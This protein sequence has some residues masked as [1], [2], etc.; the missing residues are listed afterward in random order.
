MNPNPPRSSLLGRFK[1]L[2]Q[3]SVIYGL[4]AIIQRLSGFIL[5]P[6]YTTSLS[7]SDYAIL[8]LVVL[9]GQI[10]E[11]LF[12]M[13]L[14]SSMFRSY[15][16]Y[17]T[18][19]ERKVVVATTYAM[20]L[21]S[22][23]LLIAI[24]TV[25]ATPLAAILL[26]D[27][28]LSVYLII[29]FVG[30]SVGMFNQV[31]FDLLRLEERAVTYSSLRFISFLVETIAIIW[32][33]AGLNWGVMGVLLGRL[34]A[35]SLLQIVLLFLSWRYITFAFSFSEVRKMLAYGI[36]LSIAGLAGFVFTYVDRYFLKLFTNLDE[37]GLYT[38][39]YQFGMIVTF[40][41]ITPFK[42]VWGPTF[43]SAKDDPRFQ[44][45]CAKTLS[46][47]V[48]VVGFVLLGIVLFSREVIQI[49]ADEA[50][51]PAAQIVPI[52]ALTYALWSTRSVIEIGMLLRRMTRVTAVIFLIGGA[53]NIALNLLLIPTWAGYGAAFATLISFTT[54]LLIIYTYNQ[55]IYPISYEWLRLI[56]IAIIVS[57]LY[58]V[59]WFVP[60]QSLFLA[61][62]LKT[63]LICLYPLLLLV[64]GVFTAVEKR[65]ATRFITKRWAQFRA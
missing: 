52:I 3:H 26:D 20:L 39:A 9:T 63:I 33:V 25:F 35:T 65:Q 46:Y 29:V 56:K 62:G 60:T 47:L 37:V 24:G 49:I 54:M 12:G 13:S 5:I 57:I 43:L 23:V 28:N 2:G 40:L 7:V 38:L 30:T 34:F 44:E 53:V 27:A 36:P 50:F 22:T 58:A 55:R 1:R 6:L 51:W 8:G 10:A 21:L 15:Y 45:F 59:S 19:Q 61:I 4:G 16:D 48:I 18:L 31:G 17:E 64:G 42:L 41:I 11:I 14:S 32:F